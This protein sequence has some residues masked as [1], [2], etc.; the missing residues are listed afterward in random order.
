MKL[1]YRKSQELFLWHGADPEHRD[2]SNRSAFD[3]ARLR[4][5]QALAALDVLQRGANSMST[6]WQY[7]PCRGQTDK[8]QIPFMRLGGTYSD[9]PSRQQIWVIC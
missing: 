9:T 3:Y 1:R 4:Q 7:G 6:W 2:D 5:P 8:V